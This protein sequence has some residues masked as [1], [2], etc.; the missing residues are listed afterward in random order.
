MAKSICYKPLG[1]FTKGYTS[2]YSLG[3]KIKWSSL[4]GRLTVFSSHPLLAPTAETGS[5]CDF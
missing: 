2:C 3:Y 4:A 5:Y 1:K